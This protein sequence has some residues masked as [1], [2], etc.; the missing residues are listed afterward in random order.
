MVIHL[1]KLSL[2]IIISFLC[3][4]LIGFIIPHYQT[5]DGISILGYHG[6]VSDEDK[7]I[8]YK[9]DIYT[10]SESQFEH[11]IQFFYE[12]EYTVYTMKDVEE[13]LIGNIEVEDKAI[14]LTFDDGYKNFN[15]VVKPILE[16]YGF[17][18]TCFVIGK[19]VKNDKEKFLK[20][21]DLMSDEIV[22][23]YSHSYDLHRKSKN[24]FDRKIIEDLTNFEIDLDFKKNCVDSAYFAFP[25]GRNKKGIEDVLEK[26]DVKLAFTYND[27]RHCTRNDNCYEIPR[28]M[29][30]DFMPD[31]Y[32]HWIVD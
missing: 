14:V 2:L 22:E 7:E 11:H 17:H 10:L 32:I 16:K 25:Y 4:L 3:F 5:K 18:G 8:N 29:I 15:T 19:H 27:F 9:D 6:V 28:Y 21:E 24:G 26:N 13:Y 20:E 23:Y 1:K 30:V 31:W 12:N